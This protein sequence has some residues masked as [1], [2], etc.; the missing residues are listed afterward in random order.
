MLSAFGATGTLVLLDG[1]QGT[2]WRSGDLVLKPV[3]DGES[4][5]WSCDLRAS[6]PPAAPVLVPTPVRS[7]AGA[8][9]YLGWGAA[10]WID[11]AALLPGS[12]PT[13]FR[14]V[15]DLFH[16]VVAD[17]PR[18][19]FLDRRDDPWSHG[20]RVAWGERPPDGPSAVVQLVRRLLAETDPA[21]DLGPDRLVH[22]DLPGNLLLAS[23]GEGAVLDLSP[24]WRPAS[25]ALAVAAVDG[26]CWQG[27]P[28]SLL[29]A[30]ADLPGWNQ[31]LLRA[32]IYRVATRGR[33]EPD[34]T[35]AGLRVEVPVAESILERVRRGR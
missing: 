17:V 11:G 22:G 27:A 30:W 29:G 16:Q 10:R 14:V 7:V 35:G 1:G 33:H 2:S 20:D 23:T 5:A 4:H 21:V 13:R 32:M 26:V 24:Y 31:A 9:S 25:W 3:D 19:G 6:W 18:P 8:W 28:A 12:D 34:L 15:A